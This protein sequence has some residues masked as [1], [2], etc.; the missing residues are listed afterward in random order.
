MK[1][2]RQFLL[3]SY[4]PEQIKKLARKADCEIFIKV[5]GIQSLISPHANMRETERSIGRDTIEE[6]ITKCLEYVSKKPAEAG[7]SNEVLYYSAKLKQAV[8]AS[9]RKDLN[10]NQADKEKYFFIVTFLPP[11]KNTATTGTHKVTL[12]ESL[13]EMINEFHYN[14]SEIVCI[15]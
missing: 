5:N 7:K 1:T 4:E 12:K 8:I 3:E 14:I 11:K 15:D 13:I 2:F 6:L 9:Y 10:G